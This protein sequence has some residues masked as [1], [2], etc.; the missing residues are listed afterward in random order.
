M[1]QTPR[2][3][4]PLLGRDGGRAREKARNARSI[5]LVLV[6]KFSLWSQAW[7]LIETRSQPSRG[8]IYAGG[9]ECQ[10]LTKRRDRSNR[11]SESNAAS[12]FQR[13]RIAPGQICLTKGFLRQLLQR[14]RSLPVRPGGSNDS[15]KQSFLTP[16]ARRFQ[17]GRRTTACRE[18]PLRVESVIFGAPAANVRRWRRGGYA[19]ISATQPR[20][21]PKFLPRRYGLSRNTRQTFCPPKPKEFDIAARTRASRASLGTTSSRIAGSGSR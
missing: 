3:P 9:S 17:E 14:P 18:L 15:R 20:P 4:F 16:R 10:Q 1:A 13:Q 19:A 12:N 5:R 6:S 7:R 21:G 11:A 2:S 8:V